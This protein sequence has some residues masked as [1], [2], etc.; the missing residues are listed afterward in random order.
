MVPTAAPP[1]PGPEW[2]LEGPSKSDQVETDT[3]EEQ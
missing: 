2:N 1:S 3:E